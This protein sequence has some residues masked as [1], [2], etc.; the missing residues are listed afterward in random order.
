M[1][2]SGKIG[3]TIM[4]C[5]IYIRTQESLNSLKLTDRYEPVMLYELERVV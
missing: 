3:T 5:T 1:M 4:N 2:D